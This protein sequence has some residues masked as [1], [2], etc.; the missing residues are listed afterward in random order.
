MLRYS[1]LSEC[2]IRYNNGLGDYFHLNFG[3]GRT[4][5]SWWQPVRT[6]GS[7]AP[8]SIL[9]TIFFVHVRNNVKQD[10]T[11]RK[12]QQLNAPKHMGIAKASL[13]MASNR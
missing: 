10:A 2:T 11:A 3:N 7:P 1:I 13:L 5:T 9:T 6:F 8:D 12:L 4:A